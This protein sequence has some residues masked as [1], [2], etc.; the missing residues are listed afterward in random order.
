MDGFALRFAESCNE[1]R[2]ESNPPFHWR[3]NFEMNIVKLSSGYLIFILTGSHL[4]LGAQNNK[5]IHKKVKKNC[6]D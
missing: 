5:Q 1:Y 2:F 3:T 6:R 4:T